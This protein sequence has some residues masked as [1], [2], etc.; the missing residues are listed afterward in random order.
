[1]SKLCLIF[2]INLPTE[3]FFLNLQVPV[4]IWLTLGNGSSPWKWNVHS[5]VNW[6][7]S[8]LSQFN[9]KSRELMLGFISSRDTVLL[10]KNT[11]KRGFISEVKLLI[12]MLALATYIKHMYLMIALVFCINISKRC[13]H[14]NNYTVINHRFQHLILVPSK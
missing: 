14:Y 4:T 8:I 2:A 11:I 5:T 12:A 9:D 6:L 3:T 1:M 13:W 10:E 7:I